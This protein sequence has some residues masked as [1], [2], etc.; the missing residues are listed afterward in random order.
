[1][2]SLRMTFSHT[3]AP[4]G[5]FVTPFG[6]QHE[7]GRQELLVVAGDAVLIEQRTLR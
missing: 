7:A 5:T 3:S 2:P 4:A 1:M 6:V